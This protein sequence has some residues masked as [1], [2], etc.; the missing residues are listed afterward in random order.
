MSSSHLPP[1]QNFTSIRWFIDTHVVDSPKASNLRKLYE[2]G[3][4]YLQVPDTVITEL[5]ST[6][7]PEIREALLDQ[8]SSF[9]VSMGPN[10]LG[11]SLI[12]YSLIG[13]KADRERI[14]AIH[15][16]L[17]ERPFHA[18]ASSEGSRTGLTRARDTLIVNNA[19]HYQADALIT[20]DEKI[21]NRYPRLHSISPTFKAIT[22]GSAI[23]QAL[24]SIKRVRTTSRMPLPEWPSADQSLGD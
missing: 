13:S 10:V 1:T 5:A 4:I 12:G 7:N 2:L 21:L 23:N 17:W 14:D 15:Q 11:S 16:V 8:S 18:D 22:I 24:A 6:N 19:I 3:W 9:M 20:Q